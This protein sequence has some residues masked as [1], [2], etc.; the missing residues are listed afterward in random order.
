MVWT[1]LEGQLR[2]VRR[3]SQIFTTLIDVLATPI[4]A[5]ANVLN[6]DAKVGAGK[7]GKFTDSFTFFIRVE[8]SNSWIAIFTMG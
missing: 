3:T 2:G 8:A 7:L 6:R 5:L 1:V 4:Y